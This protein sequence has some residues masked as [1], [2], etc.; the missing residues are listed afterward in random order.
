ML[1]EENTCSCQHI[2]QNTIMTQVDKIP[3]ETKERLGILINKYI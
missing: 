3:A 2:L 1:P